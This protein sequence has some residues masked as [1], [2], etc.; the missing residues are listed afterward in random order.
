MTPIVWLII[1]LVVIPIAYLGWMLVTSDRKAL[2]AVQSNLGYGLTQTSS[3]QRRPLALQNL[4][5]RAT[6]TG[7]AARL[8]RWLSMAGR[9]QSMPLDRLLVAKPALA[10]LGALLGMLMMSGDFSPRGLGLLLFVATFLYFLPDM[11]VYNRGIKRQQAIEQELPNTLDQM[12][13]SVEAGLGF[14]SAMARSA[15]NGDGPLAQELIRTLQDIQVGRPRQESYQALANRCT[16]QDLKSFVRAIIQADKYGVP[17]AKVLRTQAKV[18]RVKRRQ[19]AEEKAL[20]LPV[21]VLF[22]LIFCI[23]PVIFIVILGPAVINMMRA[24]S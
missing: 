2:V 1:S 18:A 24:F 6:P 17:I 20:K 13:I 7:Y 15:Q 10:L 14:E 22:P 3:A 9:P 4:A 19:R 12:L 11:L 16:V 5:R 21:K 8:D 23:F